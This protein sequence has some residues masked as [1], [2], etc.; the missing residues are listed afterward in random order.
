[1][2]TVK[3]M[4]VASV[5]AVGIVLGF[6]PSASA[7]PVARAVPVATT[8]ISV[9]APAAPA[10]LGTDADFGDPRNLGVGGSG[11]GTYVWLSRT[12]QTAFLT[13]T[14]AALVGALC[15]LGAAVCIVAGVIIAVGNVYV[16]RYGRCPEAS[17]YLRIRI[18][19]TKVLGCYATK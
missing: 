1:M 4:L 8:S 17:P 10:A 15:L 5:V 7:A 16:D 18:A 2:S 9:A 3:T 11:G 14:G 12:D 6:A 13:G 19:Y